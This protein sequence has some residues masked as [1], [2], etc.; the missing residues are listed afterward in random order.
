[1]NNSSEWIRQMAPLAVSVWLQSAF[2]LGIGLTA[3]RA[4]RRRGALMQVLVLRASLA[5]CITSGM[6]LFCGAH[7]LRP[8]WIVVLPAPSASTPKAAE[9]RIAVSELDA[10]FDAESASTRKPQSRAIPKAATSTIAPNAEKNARRAMANA[11]VNVNA[12]P[13]ASQVKQE[14]A[15]VHAPGALPAKEMAIAVPNAKPASAVISLWLGLVWLLGSGALFFWMMLGH[16]H[17]ARL[18]RRSEPLTGTAI[19]EMLL[20]LCDD[21]KNRA[22]RLLQSRDINAPLLCGLWRPAIVLPLDAESWNSAMQRA[23]IIHEK[24]HWRGATCGGAW[25][26]EFGARCCGRNLCCGLPAAFWQ[27]PAKKYAMP[28]FCVAALRRASTRAACSL[29]RSGA[30]RENGTR[31][32][33]SRHRVSFCRGASLAS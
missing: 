28:P 6:L 33:A 20:L 5:A 31:Q 10:I 22:P 21:A 29:W 15:T 11:N 17:V 26:R 23:V 27:A 1:M 3:A 24:T 12:A 4:L 7:F 8:M 19:G 13:N 25:R 30:H 14:S 9:T 32:S 18:R 2:L 16:A